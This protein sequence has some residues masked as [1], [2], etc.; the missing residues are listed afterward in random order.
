MFSP[1]GDG[2]RKGSEHFPAVRLYSA[3]LEIC[4]IRL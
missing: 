3:G 2:S 1:Y 4:A